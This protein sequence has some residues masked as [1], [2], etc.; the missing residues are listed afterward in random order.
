ML[1]VPSFAGAIL[2]TMLAVPTMAMAEPGQITWTTW[3]RIG[4]GRNYA[5]RDEI[6][7]DTIVEVLGCDSGW[8]RVIFGGWT[9]YVDAAVI[10]KPTVPGPAAT[11]HDCVDQRRAGYGKGDLLSVCER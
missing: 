6:Q 10:E 2:I 11:P 5:V 7:S 8:C 4:P 9:G 1:R 3:F